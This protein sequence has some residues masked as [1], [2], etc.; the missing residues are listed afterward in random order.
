MK[1]QKIL[2]LINKSDSAQTARLSFHSVSVKC[3]T[4]F[5][6]R[7]QFQLNYLHM[8]PSFCSQWCDISPT[9]PSTPAFQ[10]LP[11]YCYSRVSF[12]SYLS[13]ILF[14]LHLFTI[15]LIPDFNMSMIFGFF[16]HLDEWLTVVLPS[17]Q[18]LILFLSQIF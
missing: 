12:S 6:C 18:D 16:S 8:S 2:V 17:L 7:L 13:S 1:H 10:A 11:I 3:P 15:Q 14:H 5:V 9:A 4:F